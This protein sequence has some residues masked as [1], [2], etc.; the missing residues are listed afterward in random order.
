MLIIVELESKKNVMYM[1]IEMKKV[2]IPARFKSVRKKTCY[3]TVR[4]HPLN[5]HSVTCALNTLYRV[6]AGH[7]FIRVVRS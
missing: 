2:V 4:M 7:E 5:S 1:L 6:R 3:A